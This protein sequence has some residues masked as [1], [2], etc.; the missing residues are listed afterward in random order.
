MSMIESATPAVGD[1]SV[2]AEIEIKVGVSSRW[3]A[4]ALSEL[5]VPFHS[6]LVLHTM[7]R[8][9]VHARAPGRHGE[10]LT[11]ALRAIDEWCA[12]RRLDAAARVDLHWRRKRERNMAA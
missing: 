8:W 6:D 12:E 1:R 9:V 10:S 3:D 7:D 11:E 4:L 2:H 5:L